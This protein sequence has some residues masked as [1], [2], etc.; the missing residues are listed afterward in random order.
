M[1][2]MHVRVDTLE[3]GLAPYV[4]VFDPQTG[5]LAMLPYSPALD[6]L[7]RFLRP[8]PPSAGPRSGALPRDDPR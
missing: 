8:L 4:R 5:T 6:S 1:N 2:K 7:W 3:S